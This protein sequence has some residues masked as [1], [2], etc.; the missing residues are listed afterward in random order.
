MVS[1]ATFAACT[2]ILEKY[3]G[4]KHFY[5]EGNLAT[6]KKTSFINTLK[7]RGKR[8]IAEATLDRKMLRK[9]LRVDP[10]QLY[11]HSTI[12]TQASIM[13]G[14]ANNGGHAANSITAMFMAC[15][16]DVANVTESSAGIGYCELTPEGDLYVSMTLPSLIV[17]TYGGGTG[18]PTQRECLDV[19]GCYGKNKARKFA[20]IVAGVAVA[21]ELSLAAAI[22]SSDWVDSHERYGRNR[23]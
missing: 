5:L 15:G 19:M 1:K 16:Q 12:A 3:E 17:A 9:Y 14:S 20:E 6:D 22:S 4:I 21:G 13:A 11:Y 8:V 2:W 10:E 23:P 18:L 7:T